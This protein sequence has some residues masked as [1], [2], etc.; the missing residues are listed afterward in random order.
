MAEK[1][2][3]DEI[4]V[5]NK[6]LDKYK[7]SS[8]KNITIFTDFLNLHEQ[9]LFINSKKQF[10]NTNYIL[11]GGYNYN[12]RK[13]IVFY[14]DY[15][16]VDEIIY[17]VDILKIS[18]NNNK[19]SNKLTHRDFLGSILGLGITRAKI[20][21]IVTNE[22]FAIVFVN[23]S[24]SEYI[25]SNLHLVKN[26]AVNVEKLRTLPTEILTPK[27]KLIKGTISSIRLDSIVSLAFPLS[28]A[29]ATSM[30]KS[31][32]VYINSQLIIS[33]SHK[34]HEGDIV[35]VRGM[36]KF[37]FNR[38]GNKTKKDRINIELKRYI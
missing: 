14:P 34:L 30:I 25:I 18:P 15:V 4:L 23:C 9:N 36:G 24:V 6:I 27:Y 7:Y 5:L 22:N 28:R 11:Y 3:N 26:T 33:P 19:Y 37:L 31:K 21:D 16:N 8:N 10:S 29:K 35:S 20:G 2:N 17:P 13:V 12:E 32:N 1:R 38:I